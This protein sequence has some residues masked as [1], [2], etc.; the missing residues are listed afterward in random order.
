MRRIDRVLGDAIDQKEIVKAARAWQGLDRW[1]EVVG[2]GMA[3]RSWPDRFEHGTVY[4]ATTGSAWAQE[5]RMKKPV[6]LS[7]L[8]ELLGNRTLVQDV[9]FGV[10][11]LPERAF[12]SRRA[13]VADPPGSRDQDFL[14]LKR[15]I[16]SRFEEEE[17]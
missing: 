9:R 13:K 11:E 4:V 7:R 10:R 8:G 3:Q 15:K 17:N 1:P 16:L 12:T 5:L 14:E 2:E 6:I